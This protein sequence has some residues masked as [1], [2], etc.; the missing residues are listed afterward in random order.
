MSRL[1]DWV[2]TFDGPI[3]NNN[4]FFLTFSFICCVL[5]VD[6]ESMYRT[7]TRLKSQRDARQMVPHRGFL[8]LFRQD[9][10]SVDK[11]EKKL[12]DLEENLRIEQSDVSLSGQVFTTVVSINVVATSSYLY[13]VIYNVKE[14]FNLLSYFSIPLK[15]LNLV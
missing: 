4:I 15:G 6:A 9:E 7:L 13:Y 12:E 11:C 2:F 3:F 1:I 8:G 5:Q 10:N 14:N